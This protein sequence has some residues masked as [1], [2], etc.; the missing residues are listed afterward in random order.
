MYSCMR[1][2]SI[3]GVDGEMINV[4]ADVSDGLPAFSLVGLLSSEV[5]EAG[6]RVRNALKNSGFRMQPKH[7]TINLSPADVKK[8][9]SGFD[10]AIAMAILC[11]YEYMPMTECESYLFLGELGLD[12]MLKPVKGVLPIVDAAKKQ[13]IKFCI[14][15]YE[16]LS[17]AKLVE[18]LDIFGAKSLK[19]VIDYFLTAIPLCTEAEAWVEPEETSMLDFADI[20]GQ[21]AL[22]RAVTIAASGMHNILIGGPPGAGKSMI[23][24]RIPAILPDLTYRESMELTKIYSVAGLLKKSGTLMRKRPFRAPHHTISH[25]ALIG[26][27]M[28]PR[29]GE[30]S[31]A[32]CGVLFL[33]EFPEFSKNVIEVLRQPLED[34][35]VTVARVNATYTYPADFVL[36]AA[37]NMCPCGYYPDMNRCSCTEYARKKYLDR[38]SQPILDRMD[39]QILIQPAHYDELCQKSSKKQREIQDS[40]HIRAF[41]ERIHE[42]QFHRY[43]HENILFNAQ[44]EGKQLDQYCELDTEC[45]TILRN[46]HERLGLSA[47]ANGKVLR[48]ARTIADMAEAEQIQ[49]EHLLEALSYREMGGLS[50]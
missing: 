14:V 32:H 43:Q 38:I 3:H 47:R 49:S 5:R 36:V 4:E 29:P 10:L 37:M 16:N 13:G 22:K 44:L 24:K 11:A 17:E 42:I 26:G 31:L 34:R 23:A 19:E 6:E 41:V 25:S 1:S 28:I 40:K 27:G 45:R 15:P 33:D 30:I 12:G 48:V 46:A 18:G 7:I 21:I 20:K 35:K 8:S 39:I 50:R 2:G 9:G